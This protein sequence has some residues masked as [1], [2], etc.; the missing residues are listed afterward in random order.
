M[1]MSVTTGA[2]RDA[3]ILNLGLYRPNTGANRGGVSST[4]LAYHGGDTEVVG[5]VTEVVG[6]VPAYHGI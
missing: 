5:V 3:S 2:N 6:V 1:P 4:C